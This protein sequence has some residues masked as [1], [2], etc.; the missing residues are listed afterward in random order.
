MTGDYVCEVLFE[1]PV[2]QQEARDM[3]MRLQVPVAFRTS[4]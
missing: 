3:L 1:P 4:P 2:A